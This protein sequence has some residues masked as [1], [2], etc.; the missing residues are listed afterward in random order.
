[1]GDYFSAEDALAEFD[2]LF[3]ARLASS[4]AFPM[5]LLNFLALKAVIVMSWPQ[6]WELQKMS[7]EVGCGIA[8]V[9]FF[10]AGII[11]VFFGSKP[12]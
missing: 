5:F 7:M 12:K 11:F 6:W 4:P 3:A 1:L 10:L 9:L 8:F 2:A